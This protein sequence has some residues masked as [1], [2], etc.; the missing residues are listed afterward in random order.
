[1]FNILLQEIFSTFGI[2]FLILAR[3][4]SFSHLAFDSST[5]F[6][7]SYDIYIIIIISNNNLLLIKSVASILSSYVFSTLNFKIDQN[8]S[9]SVIKERIRQK[10]DV[11]E[12]EFSKV[13]RH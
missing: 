13:R 8:E 2:P 9:F 1:M 3:N 5:V 6:N 12:K 11:P 4:V 7:I 10:L